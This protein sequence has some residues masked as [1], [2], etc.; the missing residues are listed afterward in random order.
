MTQ[1][2]T[3]MITKMATT[4]I[5]KM[6]TTTRQQHNNGGNIKQKEKYKDPHLTNLVFFPHLVGEAEHEKFIVGGKKTT[7]PK[8]T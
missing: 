2:T 7:R 4:T 5:T 3:A 8:W 1:E 6:L